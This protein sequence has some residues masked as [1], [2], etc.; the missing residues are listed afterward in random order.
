M[1]NCVLVVEDEDKL[2]R[3]IELQL[4]SCG[5]DVE[6]AGTAEEG[7][8]LA[9][10]AHVVVTDLRLP[11]MNGL[12]LLDALRRQNSNTPVIVMTAFGTIENAVEAMKSGAADFLLKPFSLEHLVT[13][14]QKALEVRALRAEN[15]QLKE[16]LD[17]RFAFDNIIGRSTAMQEIFAHGGARRA[18]PRDGAALRREWRRQRP[19]RARHP[20]PLSAS[21]PALCEDQLHCIA[22][23]PDGKRV[24]RI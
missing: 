24:I 4:R 1:K 17:Q 10:H 2:R 13:V 15:L 6:Q 9:D 12:Q 23:E 19:D 20:L 21:R 18:N 8:R 5:Y 3:V 11:G 22:R 16:E 7:L 14:V